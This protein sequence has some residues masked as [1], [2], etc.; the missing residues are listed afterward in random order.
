MISWLQ[1]RSPDAWHVVA[2]KLNWDCSHDVL[3]W[4]VSQPQCDLATAALLF[5]MGEPDGWLK[6]PNVDAVPRI[7]LDNFNLIRKLAEGANSGFYTRREL[8][9]AG[10]SNN[11]IG[12]VDYFLKFQAE[13]LE[14]CFREGVAGSFPW[15]FP[16]LLVPPIPGRV[17]NVSPEEH[18]NTGKRIQ[19]LLAGLGTKVAQDPVRSKPQKFQIGERVNSYQGL[20]TILNVNDSDF[21]FLY[22]VRLDNGT[23]MVWIENN[24]ERI[25]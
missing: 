1:Q 9:F 14:R 3:E 20:G 22:L 21:K 23:E 8:V 6:Y 11:M 10:D 25:S 18:P 24:I 19:E 12:G 15:E 13:R 17:P 16:T 4:I 2:G 7:H 5:W